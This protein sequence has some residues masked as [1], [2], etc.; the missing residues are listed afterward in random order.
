MFTYV[1]WKLQCHPVEYH[2][3]M[4]QKPILAM[5]CGVLRPYRVH[6]HRRLVAEL[7]E[8][9]LHTLVTHEFN[10]VPTPEVFDPAI[11]P[12]LFGKGESVTT[13]GKLRHAGAAWRK[14]G[15]IVRW[16]REHR[17]A[18]VICVG[19]NDASFVRVVRWCRKNAVPCF[20]WGDSNI[21]NDRATG[22]KA[23]AKT[24][25]LRS[26]IQQCTGVLPCGRL[27]KQYFQKYGADPDRIYFAPYEP[28][29]EAIAAVADV[30]VKAVC[31]ELQLR[32][33]RKRLIYAGRLVR[34]KRIDLLIAAF[35]DIADQRPDWD[36]LIVGQGVEEEKLLAMAPAT[37]LGGTEPRIR[38]LPFVV[39]P[40]KLVAVYRACDIFVLPSEYE[41]WG[42]VVNEAIAAGLAVVASDVVGAA[43]ELVDEGVNGFIFQSGDVG[44]LSEKMLAATAADK[45]DELK[46]NASRT[47]ARWR[48]DADPV[49]G[50][51]KALAAAGLLK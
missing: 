14:G 15:R 20:L 50:V 6:F 13:Q 51:R 37:L 31:T 26:L 5:V 40:D 42:L 7:P 46:A 44:E 34:R 22:W 3:A 1:L 29:Y 43:H 30:A 24:A 25:Y 45:I 38:W 33:D 28:D 49:A 48:T 47:L 18:A 12:T 10:I 19:Y 16:L 32:G 41:A 9:E 35:A 23:R 11:R 2:R 4:E 39:D 27:G 36:L 21:R 17:A 8:F